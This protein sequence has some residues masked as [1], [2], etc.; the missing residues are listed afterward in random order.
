MATR[1]TNYNMFKP[2]RGDPADVTKLNENWDTIDRELEN[3]AKLGDDGKVLPEQLPETDM[4]GYVEKTGD[5]LTGDLKFKNTDD[6]RAIDKERIL[7][8]T[9]YHA[10]FGCG[11]L[12]G[13]GCNTLEVFVDGDVNEN[14]TRLA[15]LE[16]SERGVSFVNRDNRRT[17]LYQN[18]AVSASIES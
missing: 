1:T 14:G 7:N 5:T 18:A 15:R 10:N 2:E 11:I 4:D 3:R 8:G 17:Y 6:Y 9:S 13:E 12:G 16:V